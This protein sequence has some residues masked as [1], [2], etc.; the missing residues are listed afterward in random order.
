MLKLM[1]FP[2]DY[3]DRRATT[4]V[5][6]VEYLFWPAL[7]TDGA[8]VSVYVRRSALEDVLGLALV[9]RLKPTP[10]EVLRATLL[11]HRYR[12][13]TAA[14]RLEEA[15]RTTGKIFLEASDLRD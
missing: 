2:F 9:G 6:D 7:G 12:I 5:F 4:R 11:K 8:D 15:G 1:D 10:G 13:E 3:S 14:N